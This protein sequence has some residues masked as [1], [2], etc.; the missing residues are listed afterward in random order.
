MT[1]GLIAC[2]ACTQLGDTAAAVPKSAPCCSSECCG[3]AADL[4]HMQTCEARQTAARNACE[5]WTYQIDP[6]DPAHARTHTLWGDRLYL[7]VLRERGIKAHAPSP[8][9]AIR[10]TAHVRADV[11]AAPVNADQTDELR[12]GEALR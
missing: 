10:E 8:V 7:D 5:A 2:S 9:G 12:R 3:W 11:R 6:H 1:T 4:Q